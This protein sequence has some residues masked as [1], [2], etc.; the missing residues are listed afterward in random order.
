MK[1]YFLASGVAT[2]LILG[3]CG[4]EVESENAS[5]DGNESEEMKQLTEENESLKAEV[6]ELEL[7]L[8]EQT[9]LYNESESEEVEETGQPST[10]SKAG[11]RTEPL[12]LGDTGTIS[13]NTYKDDE[14]MT[15]VHGVAEITVENVVRG[16]EATPILTT[17]YS[18]AEPAPAGMEWIVFDTTI[19]L[20][21]ISDE[22]EEITFSEDFTIFTEDGSEIEKAY[23]TFD[24]AFDIQKV[25]SG[26]VAEG[27]VALHAPVGEPFMIKYDDYLGALAFYQVD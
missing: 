18:E 4:A 14:D 17:E 25:Y 13:I 8:E 20:K 23:T 6:E 26:G 7:A 24:E 3:A 27:K 19:S 15:P 1:K 22:N 21:E 5:A 9:E 12:T 2:V 16:E 10:E 11:T